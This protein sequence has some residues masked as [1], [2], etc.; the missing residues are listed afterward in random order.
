MWNRAVSSRSWASR[1]TRGRNNMVVR[2]GYGFYYD[3]S[4][5]APGEGLY[6][7]PPYFNFKIYFP[8]GATAPLLLN[9]P[10]PA[11]FPLPTPPSALAFQRD[12][13]TPYMQQ[14][15]FN[16]ERTIGRSRLFEIGY[17]GS[18][19]TRLLGARDIN[20]PAPTNAPQ[21]VRPVPIF[22]DINLLE[23]ARDSI[24]HSLQ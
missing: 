5:L 2:A 13:R 10:F 22:E 19:G 14:W 4:S 17:V 6:F 3:Q 20:Q 7:S 18:K 21:Y 11:N 23:S 15:N 24:Y 12:L 1:A 8:L 16:F 9:D